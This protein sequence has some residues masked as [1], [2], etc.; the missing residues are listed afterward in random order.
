M[1]KNILLAVEL[2]TST[3][4]IEEKALTLKK[5]TDAKL[6]VIHVVAPLPAAYAIGEM[7]M[8]VNLQEAKNSL[9]EDAKGLLKP[10]ADR[11]TIP[12]DQVLVIEGHESTEILTYA[13]ENGV[14]LIVSGSHGK[15]GIQLLLGSTAN[16]ILHGSECDV[17]AVRL[18]R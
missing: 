18:K 4:F 1:Y 15:H 13:K 6:T 5:L 11:L 16:A 10:I 12:M 8:A 7:G 3:K 9:L 17:L 14:D 2:D